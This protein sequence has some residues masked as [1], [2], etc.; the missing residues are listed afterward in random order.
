MKNEKYSRMNKLRK[1]TLLAAMAGVMVSVLPLPAQRGAELPSEQ[2]WKEIE[3][4]LT[5]PERAG[6]VRR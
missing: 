2:A 5:P 1:R 4:G 6:G 3:A